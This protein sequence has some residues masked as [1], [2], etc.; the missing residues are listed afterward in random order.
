MGKLTPP[1]LLLTLLDMYGSSNGEENDTTVRVRQR[2]TEALSAYE[3]WRREPLARLVNGYDLLALGFPEGPRVG[4]ILD[5]I[6]E[7]QISGEITEKS[8]ALEYA[9]EQ[10]PTTNTSKN[11]NKG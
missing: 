11:K 4:K 3:D 7:K 2:C 6:R 8:A 10:L 9:R 1:L 5:N